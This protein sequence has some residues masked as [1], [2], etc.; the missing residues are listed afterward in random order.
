M[1]MTQKLLKSKLAMS[2]FAQP[3]RSI[4]F[5]RLSRA[6]LFFGALFLLLVP[7]AI[8]PAAAQNAEFR[9]LLRRLEAMED[10]LSDVQRELFNTRQSPRRITEPAVTE[11]AAPP[12][13]IPLPAAGTEGRLTDI[14]TS[15]SAL[16][17]DIETIGH[18]VD[19]MNARMDRLVADVDFRLSAIEKSLAEI[20]ARLTEGLPVASDQGPSSAATTETAALTPAEEESPPPQAPK[21]IPDG[22]PQEQ[23]T[24]A[25]S[26]LTRLDYVSAEIAFQEFLK[27]NPEDALA[28]NAYYWLGETY[29][30][31][32]NYSEAAGSFYEGYQRFPSGNKAPDNLLKLGMSLGKME[33]TDD[34]CATLGEL[35]DQFPN[36]EERI[37]RRVQQVRSGLGC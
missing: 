36:A 34:A 24:F 5:G 7:L 9:E 31:R 17:G 18:R 37:T 32:K 2:G 1:R 22:T 19:L 26:L 3:F 27:I 6:A 33:Q 4:P 35:L 15:M 23:Y 25:R 8:S 21:I 28:G 30:V 13:A 29:Y 16:T 12:R 14:E 10:S 11:V 20:A